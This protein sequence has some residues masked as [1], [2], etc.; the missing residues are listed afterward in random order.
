MQQSEARTAKRIKVEH[1]EEQSPAQSPVS[2]TA[3]QQPAN[4]QARPGGSGSTPVPLALPAMRSAQQMG[5]PLNARPSASATQSYNNGEVSSPAPIS[6]SH[7]P[8]PQPT[9]GGS[10]GNVGP[11]RAPYQFGMGLPTPGINFT[12][13]PTTGSFVANNSNSNS[14]QQTPTDTSRVASRASPSEGRA[15]LQSTS[16]QPGSSSAGAGAPKRDGVDV[17]Q[18]LLSISG[19]DLRVSCARVTRK[20]G[21]V[22]TSRIRSCSGGGGGG[23]AQFDEPDIVQH[24]YR[25]R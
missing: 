19:V 16:A 14:R 21:C 6:F 5:P 10:R 11:G 1:G 2:S 12:R 3:Q 20:A 25:C 9:P 4:G 17:L 13:T 24:G 8:S 23:S 18:D 7:S 15:G 22:L